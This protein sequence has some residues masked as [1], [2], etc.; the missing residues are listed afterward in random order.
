MCLYFC[1]EGHGCACTYACDSPRDMPFLPSRP[2]PLQL[3][4]RRKRKGRMPH[5]AASRGGRA[6]IEPNPN[7]IEAENERELRRIAG[8]GWRS[9]GAG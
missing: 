3:K 6:G 4:S 8:E 9:S 7:E 2:R 1:V 5:L